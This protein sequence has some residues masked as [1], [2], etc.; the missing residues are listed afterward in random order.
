MRWRRAGSPRQS[1]GDPSSRFVR[2]RTSSTRTFLDMPGI[3]AVRRVSPSG[4]GFLQPRCGLTGS[5][6]SPGGSGQ[7]ISKLE[8][9][10]SQLHLEQPAGDLTTPNSRGRFRPAVQM[11]KAEPSG[12]RCDIRRQGWGPKSASAGASTR[13]PEQARPGR[14]S[15]APAPAKRWKDH[16]R[17]SSRCPTGRASVQQLPVSNCAAGPMASR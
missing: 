8:M 5:D 13:L 6:S 10:L 9:C 3:L 1:I 11:G 2:A 16:L 4:A 12:I 14:A 7:K 15:L 17:R